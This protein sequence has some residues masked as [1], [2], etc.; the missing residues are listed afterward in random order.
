MM[1]LHASPVAVRVHTT[2][3]RRSAMAG[4][5]WRLRKVT[6]VTVGAHPVT[7]PNEPLGSAP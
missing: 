5:G 7:N 4:Q 3:R 1:M 6:R 2:K